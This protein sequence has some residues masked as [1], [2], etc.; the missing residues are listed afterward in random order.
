MARKKFSE[1][2]PG[3]RAAVLTGIAL[4]LSLALAAWVDLAKRPASKVNGSKAKWAA[5]IS[6]NFIGPIAYFLR[7]RRET[8]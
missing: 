7:G 4:Q 3:Q 8:S 6:V 5:I 1:L 2:S